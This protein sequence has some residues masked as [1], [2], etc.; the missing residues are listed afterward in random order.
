VPPT[1]EENPNT[2]ETI[3]TQEGFRSDMYHIVVTIKNQPFTPYTD[4]DGNLIRMSYRIDYKFD[5]D[6]YWSYLGEP[7]ASDSEYTESAYICGRQAGEPALRN[8]HP[9][10]KLNFRVQAA[11]GTTELSLFD[12]NYISE[13]SGWSGIQTLTIPDTTPNIMILSPQK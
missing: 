5:V 10:D 8:L 11:I 1:Y 6:Q 7:F 3:I 9:G 2:G 13:K 4:E 12:N